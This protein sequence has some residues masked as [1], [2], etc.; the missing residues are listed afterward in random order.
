MK[1]RAHKK[2]MLLLVVRNPD[3]ESQIDLIVQNLVETSEMTRG[4]LKN[5]F[6]LFV[7][8]LEEM[9]KKLLNCNQYFRI[10]PTDDINIFVLFVKSQFKIS[11]MH[12]MV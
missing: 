3:D 6:N 10:A 5:R 7:I 11:I 4:L 9:E 8:S 12:R 2:P 1:S